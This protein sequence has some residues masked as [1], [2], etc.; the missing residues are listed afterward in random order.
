MN[1]NLL[2]GLLRENDDTTADYAKVIKSSKSTA[3][4]R[5]NGLSQHTR[6]ELQ[7]VKSHYHLSNERFLEIFFTTNVN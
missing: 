5:I 7:A 4:S 1:P 6:D 2:K 3:F